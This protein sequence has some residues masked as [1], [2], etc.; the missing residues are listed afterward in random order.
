M[1]YN[2]W[3]SSDTEHTTHPYSVTI[4]EREDS[5]E[6]ISDEQVQD[7]VNT[8]IEKNG[9]SVLTTVNEDELDAA[10]AEVLT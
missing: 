4:V 1:T 9:V 10:L 2:G 6:I 7:A 8:Y 5:G 3:P